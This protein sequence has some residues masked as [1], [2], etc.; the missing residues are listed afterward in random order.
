MSSFNE[1]IPINSL[2]AVVGSADTA[3]E[4]L[5]GATSKK[6]HKGV[7]IKNTHGSQNLF[8]GNEN[9]TATTGFELGPDEEI[10]LE[11]EDPSKIYV[12]G[13]GRV[14]LTLGFHTNPEVKTWRHHLHIM[15]PSKMLM[16]TSLAVCTSLLG[17]KPQQE[18]GRQP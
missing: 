8:V 13:S 1:T 5:D 10:F 2:Q 4:V 18:I 12:I 9:V 15:E 14:L 7:R 17:L 3:A 16:S 11:L 6:A